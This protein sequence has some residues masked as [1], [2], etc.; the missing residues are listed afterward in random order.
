MMLLRSTWLLKPVTNQT[1]PHT[2]SVEL[3]K[4]LHGKI[5]LKFGDGEVPN[6]TLAGFL[7]KYRKSDGFITFYEDELYQLQLTGLQESASKA[8]AA[9]DLETS[10]DFLGARFD[11]CDRQQ[12]TT[13]Y[14]DL[15]QTCV[16]SEPEPTRQ[17]KLCFATPTAFAQDRL[18]LPLP[19]PIFLFR[20]WLERWN[21]FSPIYLGG[22]ELLQY[23]QSSV[24]LS[25]HRIET[26]SHF[27]HQGRIPGFTGDVTLS[28][29]GKADPLLAQVA[30]LL[31]Q[32]G[33]FAG[34]GVKT[35]LGMGFTTLKK[36]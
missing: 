36:E 30:H 9:F 10:F 35:R 13:T 4:F 11:V 26:R 29:L 8:I 14:E 27:I 5:G 3:V 1:M 6:T 21:H 20:S 2:Y 24:A 22:D 19:I 23:L 18:H 12:E 25:R 32:Y 16:A 15:Y 31:V 17:F 7:G 33:E 28:V 34:T